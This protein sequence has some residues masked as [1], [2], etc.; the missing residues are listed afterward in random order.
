LRKI[1]DAAVHEAIV[2][3]FLH[4]NKSDNYFYIVNFLL[5]FHL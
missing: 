4:R 2:F 3:L 5:Q 1:H